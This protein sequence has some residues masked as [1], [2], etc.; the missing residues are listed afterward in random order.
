MHDFMIRN[1]I[2][3]ILKAVYWRALNSNRFFQIP[4]PML[5]WKAAG[6]VIGMFEKQ[7]G[8]NQHPLKTM[9]IAPIAKQQLGGFI[10]VGKKRILKREHPPP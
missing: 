3:K 10:E 1:T 6:M 8:F 7:S 4:L 5:A 9:R 2:L